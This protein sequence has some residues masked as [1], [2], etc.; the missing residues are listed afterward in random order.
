MGTDHG[1]LRPA[2]SQHVLTEVGAPEGDVPLDPAI[3]DLR[4]PMLAVVAW[5]AALLAL[6]PGWAWSAT[7]AVVLVAGA[8]W[9][10]RG[11]RDGATTP[12]SPTTAASMR[13]TAAAAIAVFAAVGTIAQIR[14]EAE[15]RDPVAGFA[16]E[17][18]AVSAE[19]TVLSDPRPREGRFDDYVLLRGRVERVTGRGTTYAGAARVLVIAP[20]GWHDVRLGSRIG[21][22]GRL[23]PAE[24]GLSGVLTTRGDPVV[25][26]APDVWWHIA[27]R[28]RASLR[29]SV[30][31]RPAEQRAL[32][33]ALV[34]GDDAE[35]PEDLVADF[36][37]TGLTH[38]TAVSG[39]NLTLLVGFLLLAGRWVGIRGRWSLLLVIGGIGSFLLLARAEP[40]VV[41]AATMGTV[42]LVGLASGRQRGI[43]A[44]GGAVV[45][46]LL[47]DPGLATNVGFG[48][49]VL[50]TAGILFLAPAWRDAMTRWLPRWAAEAIAVPTAAQLACTPVVAG[51][52]G[53]VSLAAVGANLLAGPAVGPATVLGLLGA[54]LGLVVPWAGTVC[55]TL[56]SWC[57]AWIVLVAR[58]GADLPTAAVEWG[59]GP[60]PLILLTALCLVLALALPRMLAS[61]VTGLACCALLVL[62]A[63]V[64]PPSPGWPPEGWVLVACDVGQGDA[65]VV[66]AG[67][68]A[69][70]VVDAG[71]EPRLVD[72]CLDR[73]GVVTVPVLVLTHFHAD[74]VDGLAGVLDGRRVGEIDVSPLSDPESG[75]REVAATA[76]RAGVPSRTPPIGEVRRLGAVSWR[77]LWPTP[78][79]PPFVSDGSAANDAS[80]V[81]LVETAGVRLLLT[82]DIE[83]SAQRA[84]A[85]SLAGERVDVLK[86]P[87]HGSRFQDLGFL[88]GLA[89]RITLTS[90][91]ADNDYGHPAIDTLR[92]FSMAGV[93]TLRTDRDGDIA[94]VVRDG[95]LAAVTSGGAGG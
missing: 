46:L 76:A 53:Q 81:L 91:G 10:L 38:L 85:P 34:V 67:D 64:R 1:L 3:L 13:T 65:L 95:R 35:M 55:G 30:A 21:V 23:A 20:E 70:L 40:S 2:R 42:A 24:R 31:G 12:S 94:V 17:R 80:L 15:V 27:E 66:N 5:S 84:L 41:R 22:A 14:H 78:D 19:L 44:I 68:G 8:A 69:G 9:L 26:A 33:P 61:P 7:L 57:V 43:R 93:P 47:L 39:T 6:L 48:L 32:V 72:R 90:V 25:L 56:A 71:P 77:V 37:T 62:G 45:A 36:Q 51:I 11:R 87:H 83:P 4:L 89:P 88:A 49:S 28:V 74:H 58:Q 63:L 16:S 75:A 59:A 18:V 52:S 86:L 29:A 73:L 82:G 92:P 60:V 50:A 79:P 54:L